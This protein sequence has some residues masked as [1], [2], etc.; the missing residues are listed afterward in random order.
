MISGCENE[1]VLGG[2]VE[3]AK[4]LTFLCVSDSVSAEENSGV[5]VNESVRRVKL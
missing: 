5:E 4:K 3:F 1:R 2:R